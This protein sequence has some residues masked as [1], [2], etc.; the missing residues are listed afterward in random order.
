MGGALWLLALVWAGSIVQV[1]QTQSTARSRDFSL[2]NHLNGSYVDMMKSH[3]GRDPWNLDVII[4]YL[5]EV[6]CSKVAIHKSDDKAKFNSI[7]RRTIEDYIKV[8]SGD[9]VPPP[10]W[11]ET[12]HHG[13]CL[14]EEEAREIAVKELVFS[15]YTLAAISMEAMTETRLQFY[16]EQDSE[17]FVMFLTGWIEKIWKEFLPSFAMPLSSVMNSVY[18]FRDILRLRYTKGRGSSARLVRAADDIYRGLN[19]VLIKIVNVGFEIMRKVVGAVREKFIIF[20]NMFSRN[21]DK[22]LVNHLERDSKGSAYP[23]ITRYWDARAMD[24]AVTLLFRLKASKGGDAYEIDDLFANILKKHSAGDIKAAM[25]LAKRG[26]IESKK[27]LKF[28]P[29]VGRLP[30]IKLPLLGTLPLP[31]TLHDLNLMGVPTTLHEVE[32]LAYEEVVRRYLR[33]LGN[34]DMAEFLLGSSW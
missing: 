18:R 33:G 28:S 1:V 9:C 11:K 22:I 25:I 29:L 34:R 2:D 13:E 31:A 4:V 19:P 5:L 8:K 3:D 10:L 15:M 14:T 7:T 17:D 23:S 27:Y 12:H 6:L 20:T 32:E 24:Y 26:L 16:T 21:Y 30:P